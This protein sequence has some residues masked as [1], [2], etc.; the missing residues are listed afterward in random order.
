MMTS[1]LDKCV[2]W[3]DFSETWNSGRCVW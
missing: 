2:G 1:Y 3:N